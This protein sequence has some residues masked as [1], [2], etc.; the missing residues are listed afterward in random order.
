MENTLTFSEKN[1]GWTSFFSYKTKLMAKINNRFFTFQN[2]QLWIHNDENVDTRNNFYGEQYSSKVN[3]IVNVENAEDKIFKT[4]VY[5]GN[6]SWD[7]VLKT[8]LTNGTIKSTEFNKRESRWFAHTR[9]NED[10]NSF[11]GG[12]TQ[13]IGL[14]ESVIADT[15][16]FKSHNLFY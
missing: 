6:Q 16:Y 12:A 15:I 7:A 8:N 10:E 5:E 9:G 1:K 14:I 4:L 13:G 2:G 3:T 11:N